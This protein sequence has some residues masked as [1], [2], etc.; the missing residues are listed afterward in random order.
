LYVTT[1]LAPIT[2]RRARAI[3]ARRTD[4]RLHLGSG[5]N[6]LPEWVNID[7]VGMGSDLA[8]DLRRR[9]PFPDGSARAAFL[10][11]VIE[12]FAL[13]D[14][15]KDCHRLLAAGGTIR[16]GVPDF[17]RYIRSY[18]GDGELIEQ[19]RPN[20]PTPLLAVAEV[21]QFHGHRSDYD[22]ETLV[23]L[24]EKLG[25][26]KST[27]V[28]SESPR[29]STPFLTWRCGASI[30]YMPRARGLS[31]GRSPGPCPTAIARSE[32]WSG[33][34][35]SRLILTMVPLSACGLRLDASG[36][37]SATQKRAP[38]MAISDDPAVLV[39]T[40]VD[41]FVSKARS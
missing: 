6:R 29:R 32:S 38:S 7:L 9:L 12:H 25:S 22:A 23:L 4:L 8:W 11:H 16:V 10:E 30:R 5:P 14:V 3:A 40:A 21:A 1:L 27:C 19:T 28:A 41:L 13:A 15:L 33:S 35:T 37:S 24:L 39:G 31:G 20:R 18:A 2:G 36:V 17:G 34:A 26:S